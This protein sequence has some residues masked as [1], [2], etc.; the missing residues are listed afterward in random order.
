MESRAKPSAELSISFLFRYRVTRVD[1]MLKVIIISA[2]R[3]TP[4]D[5]QLMAIKIKAA[6]ESSAVPVSASNEATGILSVFSESLRAL[7]LFSLANVSMVL[8]Y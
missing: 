1:I 8:A 3:Y 4:N 7:V 6:I 5:F 2:C